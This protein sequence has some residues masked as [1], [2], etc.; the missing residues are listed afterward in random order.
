MAL[1]FSYLR[2]SAAGIDALNECVG[3]SISWLTLAMVLVTFAIVIL[4]YL[5]DLSWVPV[6][7]SVIYM[8]SIVFMLGAAYTLKQDG[9]VRVDIVYQKCTPKVQA[10]IDLMGTL[11]LLLPVAGFI[12]WSSWE[13]V[14]DSW[15]IMES[16]RNSGGLPLVYL[17]KSCLLLMSGLLV[18][19]AVALLMQKI[20]YLF[21]PAEVT[22]G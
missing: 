3:R 1:L 8:H 9:H 6:Q 7:E 13:Y 12:F 17:L 22:H 2:Q 11:L 14:M 20:V 5:F 19:Q 4:R 16:S 15:G 21:A 10:W 18:L